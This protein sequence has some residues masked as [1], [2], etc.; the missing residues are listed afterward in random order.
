MVN[1][2]KT[3]MC[4]F[5]QNQ[6]LQVLHTMSFFH[7]TMQD[8]LQWPHC[9]SCC[10]HA[11]LFFAEDLRESSSFGLVSCGWAFSRFVLYKGFWRPQAL[12]WLGCSVLGEH[13]ENQNVSDKSAGMCGR[14]LQICGI[15]QP[16]G[17]P[18]LWCVASTLVLGTSTNSR[19][20]WIF[21]LKAES[22]RQTVLIIASSTNLAHS[23]SVFIKQFNT[24]DQ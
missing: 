4:C 3:E 19:I 14:C 7:R 13:E 17:H 11:G 16:H 23:L 1:F 2:P 24:L 15:L 22:N 10:P 9:M 12:V 20:W 5:I 8:I 6:I 18:H 21:P